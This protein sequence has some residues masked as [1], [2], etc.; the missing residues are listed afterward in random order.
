MMEVKSDKKYNV[1]AFQD[2]KSRT[3]AGLSLDDFE[4][5]YNKNVMGLGDLHRLFFR[6]WR[7]IQNSTKSEFQTGKKFSIWRRS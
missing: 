4:G 2:M 1:T 7:D 3:H 5:R 6:T